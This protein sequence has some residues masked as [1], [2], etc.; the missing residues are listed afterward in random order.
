[1]D[2]IYRQELLEVFKNP[3][4]KGVLDEP[5]L[6]VTERNSFCGDVLT[7][8]LK[9]EDNKVVSAKFDGDMCMVSLVSADLLL[10]QLI[11]KSIEDLK[12]IN[13]QDVLS[14]IDVNL[15]TSRVK[16]ALLVLQA[17]QS[18]IKKYETNN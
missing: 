18:A 11:G 1:M 4:Y 15:T 16:C 9:I 17:L 7:L 8:D 12:N 2:N 13:K 5:K 10:D 6:S 3:T 14:N